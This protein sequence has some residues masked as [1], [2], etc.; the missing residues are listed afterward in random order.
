M[1]IE[2]STSYIL[3]S[4]AFRDTCEMQ[5]AT[6]PFIYDLVPDRVFT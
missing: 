1:M 6:V 4:A 5:G 3:H 2:C